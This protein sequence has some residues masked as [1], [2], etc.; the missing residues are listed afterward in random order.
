MASK[1]SN[2]SSKL[3]AEAK[4][5]LTVT[6]PLVGDRGAGLTVLADAEDLELLAP[7]RWYALPGKHTVLCLYDSW[8]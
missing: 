8:Q 7:Y 3:L 6:I 2:A 1:K 4:S 5:G